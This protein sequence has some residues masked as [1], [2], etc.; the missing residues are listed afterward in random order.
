MY[1]I[2]R[3]NNTNQTCPS[4]TFCTTSFSGVF[5]SESSDESLFFLHIEPQR[6]RV[7]ELEHKNKLISI[8]ILKY[9]INASM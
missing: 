9:N 4:N 3:N 5:Q 2:I 1:L 6:Q 8:N 7:N